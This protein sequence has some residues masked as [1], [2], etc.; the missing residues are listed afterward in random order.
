[1]SC[2]DLPSVATDSFCGA[3]A[4]SRWEFNELAEFSDFRRPRVC[5]AGLDLAFVHT[6]LQLAFYRFFVC[7]PEPSFFAVL[8]ILLVFFPFRHGCNQ[9][10]V[11]D[12]ISRWYK[13][14]TQL[15]AKHR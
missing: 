9:L 10:I 2:W 6:T 7:C 14:V 12:K 5:L 4:K 8:P 3:R 1:S 15:A 13:E 11:P